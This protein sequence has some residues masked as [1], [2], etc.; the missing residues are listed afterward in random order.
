MCFMVGA[1]SEEKR[2]GRAR[3]C[4]ATKGDSPEPLDGNR[5]IRCVEQTTLEV[6]GYG[7]EYQDFAA[8][9]LSDQD[10]VAICAKV[11]RRLGNSPRSVEPLAGLHAVQQL[12]GG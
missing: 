2:I 1:S 5:H 11:T 8:A 6:P 4:A 10:V 9:E 12:T 7:I 3:T